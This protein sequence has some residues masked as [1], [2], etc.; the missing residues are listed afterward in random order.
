MDLRQLRY[1]TAIAEE[2]QITRAAKKLHM[3]QPPLSHQL[4]L[5]EQELGVLLLERNGKEMELTEAGKTLY[6]RGKD[7]IE[8]LE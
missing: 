6:K 2:K 5:L 4:K 7:L 1:F 3:A 8:K